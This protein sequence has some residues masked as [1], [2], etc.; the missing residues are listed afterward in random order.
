M[1][2]MASDAELQ[3]QIADAL[4]I[5]PS[6][7]ATDKRTDDHATS[8]SKTA[9]VATEHL[10]TA[11]LDTTP[12]GEPIGISEMVRLAQQVEKYTQKVASYEDLAAEALARRMKGR[13][14]AAPRYKTQGEKAAA[15]TALEESGKENTLGA[16]LTR[17]KDAALDKIQAKSKKDAKLDDDYMH[18]LEGFSRALD[19]AMMKQWLAEGYSDDEAAQML[20]EH[21]Q[22]RQEARAARNRE[23]FRKD[24]LG[25]FLD[26]Y[27]NMSKGKKIGVTIGAAAVF[28]TIG[29]VAGAAGGVAAAAGGIGLAGVKVGKTYLQHRSK[30]YQTG[31]DEPMTPPNR[32]KSV[33]NGQAEKRTA[34]QQVFAGMEYDKKKR[35]QAI[36]KSDR[37][38]K[39]AVGL[40]AAAGILLGAGVVTKIVE[41]GDDVKNFFGKPLMPKVPT[42]IDGPSVGRVVEPP[43]VTQEPVLPPKPAEFSIDATTV[44]AGEGWYQTIQETTGVTDPARQAAILQKI[45]PVLQQ[46]G[47]AYPMSDG[48]WG[49]S[50]PGTLPKDV[51]ELIKNTR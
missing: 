18:L 50:R 42:D 2:A 7:T 12:A 29:V 16:K 49:I 10:S 4:A 5:E 11:H 26:K 30:I 32:A 9:P 23:E 44:T 19:G 35:E 13:L 51:L 25:S 15:Q 27:A 34:A 20:Y 41:H 36:E 8:S 33:A 22:T 37:N 24:K 1:E 40:A 38:K 21:Q 48:T 6:K 45:G 43:V 17:L 39:V 28:G 47:W 14:F 3:Q 31:K 46:K